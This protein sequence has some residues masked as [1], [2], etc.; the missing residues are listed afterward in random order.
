[1]NRVKLLLLFALFALPVAASYLAYY[2]WQPEG[3]KN[4]GELLKQV[5]IRGKGVDLAG[6]TKDIA[7]MKGKWVMVYVG[8]GAC[9][10]ECEQL[11]YYMRQT[12]KVQGKEMDRIDRLWLV[13]DAVMP[14]AALQQAHAGMHYLRSREAGMDS[15]FDGATPGMA[16]PG[17]H[18]YMVD[19][20]GHLMM[21]WPQNPDPQRIIKDIKQ[22]LKASQIG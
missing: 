19:P 5:E 13:T 8:G 18:L 17:A 6:A 1:M 3:R 22:L 7:D 21:R 9:G 2:V 10:K 4:Y 20:L 15:Q 11:L 16:I 12:R 14:G